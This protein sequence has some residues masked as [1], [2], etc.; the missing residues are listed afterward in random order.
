MSERRLK[1]A[2]ATG[3]QSTFKNLLTDFVKQRIAV[4]H[5]GGTYVD[6]RTPLR[7]AARHLVDAVLWGE[8]AQVGMRSRVPLS[9][10]VLRPGFRSR[11]VVP[12]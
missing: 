1:A 8:A 4:A 3:T 9:G 12:I 5:G 11:N 10:P 6:E 2:L 7:E